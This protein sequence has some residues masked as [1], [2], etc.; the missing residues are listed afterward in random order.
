MWVSIGR[1]GQNGSEGMS[2]HICVNNAVIGNN[3]NYSA[4][5]RTSVSEP[6]GETAIGGKL[7]LIS[8][9]KINT[10][11]RVNHDLYLSLWTLLYKV[12]SIGCSE[13]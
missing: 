3:C 12:L 7:I 10:G 8:L 5:G 9:S 2:D 1:T 6:Q 11:L 4:A 13:L